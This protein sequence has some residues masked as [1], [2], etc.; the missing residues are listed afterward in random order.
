MKILLTGATGLLGSNIA[1]EL[2]RRGHEVRVLVRKGSDLRGIAGLPVGIHYGDLL[3]ETVI[4]KAIDGCEGLIH[5]ASLTAQWP[6]DFKYYEPI[7]VTATVRLMKAALSAG[8]KRVI[9]VSTANTIGHGT[10][11]TPGT[12]L[13]EFRLFHYNS[14]YINSKYL[15]QQYVLEQVERAGLPAVVLNPTFMLGPLD[16]KPSSG[17]LIVQGLKS[18]IQW[19]PPGGK[20]FIHV[21]D[22]AVGVCNALTSGTPGECY[23]LAGENLT[24]QAF[25]DLLNE[26]TGH[27]PMQ[28]LLPGFFIKGIGW[29]GDLLTRLT[30]KGMPLNRV[31][32]RMMCIGNYYTPKKAIQE[33]G[34]PQTPVRKAVEDA[35][36]WLKASGHL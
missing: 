17:Q 5:A 33:L 15:A 4:E 32:T 31:T 8:I 6:T 9:Y 25:F 26:V 7:N 16:L 28:V 19:I 27:R 21:Q 14:G 23:L 1:H 3:D 24:Y 22:A 2:C 29:A 11:D 36:L 35:V 10:L 18:K 20:N 34:L 30:A 12:E 13:N